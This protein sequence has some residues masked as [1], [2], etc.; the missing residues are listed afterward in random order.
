MIEI[1]TLHWTECISPELSTDFYR[2]LALTHAHRGG[3]IGKRISNLVKRCDLASLCNL[4]IDYS[5]PT[6]TAD[7]FYHA[8][9]ALAFF[10]KL[11]Y[12]DI[13]IDKKRAALETF[14]WTELLCSE[15]NEIFRAWSRGEFQFHPDVDR[16]L[17]DASRL[18]AQV[19]GPVPPLKTLKLRFGPGATT[20]TKKRE[21]SPRH[22]FRA[23]LACS[24]ELLPILRDVLDELAAWTDN[25]PFA[26]EYPS[27]E[28]EP[29]LLV[30]GD[31]C[32]FTEA[33]LRAVDIDADAESAEVTC[34]GSLPVQLMDEEL[35]FAA[36][37]AKT[38]RS[39]SK[40][41]PLNS[42]VQLAYG[43]YMA[44]R[45]V[46]FGIGTRDQT[47][48]Q[49]LAREGSLTGDLATLDLRSASDTIAIELVYHLLPVDWAN[50]LS[51]C[52][53]KHVTYRNARLRLEKFSSMGNGYTFPL[54]TLIFWALTKATV[55]G[56]G[57]SVAGDAVSV[58]GDDVILP[59]RHFD[60]LGS[61]L[62]A[63]GFLVNTSKSFHTGPFRESCGADW[64]R[65]FNIRPYYARKQVSAESLFCLHN[66]YA[67][68]G[69]EDMRLIVEKAIPPALRLYGPDGVG[70][71]IMIGPFTRIDRNTTRYYGYGGS[72]F[73]M[74]KHVNI[75]EALPPDSTDMC[76]ALYSVY[77]RSITPHSDRGITCEGYSAL[78]R[79]LRHHQFLI[80][81]GTPSEPIPFSSESGFEST[82]AASLPGTNGSKIVLVYTFG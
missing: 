52:R 51:T 10:S 71:C 77:R 20:L 23:G 2:D 30:C 69:Q 46:R 14:M 29:P 26:G 5:E 60:A 73:K 42:L 41:P 56:L 81:C 44:R 6:M 36:K 72:Y 47:P 7:Q 4:N 68:S 78:G 28:A 74:H 12:L 50:A 62:K 24:D 40:P 48:N 43:D 82:K 17:S 8:R 18:I 75:K 67:R 53:C 59:S 33:T 79:N 35:S 11:E 66:Y 25:L 16:V 15:T 58:Y 65:G 3:V 19:L 64:Y 57:P 38:L 55:D 31:T 1:S 61:V 63:C 27:E 80:T 49:V 13:G 76:Q 32:V 34:R 22:K 39:V 70:D 45:L 54:E 37:N 9:Q 21:A